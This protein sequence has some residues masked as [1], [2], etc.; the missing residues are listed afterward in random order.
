MLKK[1]EVTTIIAD[2]LEELDNVWTPLAE[3]SGRHT[4][5]EAKVEEDENHD[6]I[7]TFK[8]DSF[9]DEQPDKYRIKIEYF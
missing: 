1:Y 5:S 3:D 4:L 7:F 2:A 8:E 9:S 6:L